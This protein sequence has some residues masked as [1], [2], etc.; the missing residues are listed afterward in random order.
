MISDSSFAK[1]LP[2]HPL[3]SAK[4]ETWA[5]SIIW[6]ALVPTVKEKKGGEGQE[7]DEI[8]IFD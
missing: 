2:E 6:N 7:T 1:P 5:T 4:H 8:N 3:L